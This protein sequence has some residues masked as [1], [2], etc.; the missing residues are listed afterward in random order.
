MQ[1]PTGDGVNVLKCT[2]GSLFIFFTVCLPEV[3]SM[4][5]TALY[6]VFS[7]FILRIYFFLRFRPLFSQVNL[8]AISFLVHDRPQMT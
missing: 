6:I 4:V 2:H 5:N 3:L 7:E 8:P 1:P